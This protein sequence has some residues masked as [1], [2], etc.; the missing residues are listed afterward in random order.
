MPC[1]IRSFGYIGDRLQVCHFHPAG[2]EFPTEGA[3]H[4]G[5]SPR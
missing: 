3:A 1:E 4:R 5:R 2:S